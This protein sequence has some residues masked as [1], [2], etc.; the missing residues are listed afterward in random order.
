MKSCSDHVMRVP[1]QGCPQ[2]ECR[3]TCVR[4]Q[5]VHWTNL[6]AL[7]TPCCQ[8]WRRGACFVYA[9][10]SPRMDYSNFTETFA[11]IIRFISAHAKHTS[12]EN[13]SQRIHALLPVT[14]SCNLILRNGYISWGSYC[15]KHGISQS[16]FP[17]ILSWVRLTISLL[18]LRPLP[19][20]C[21]SPRW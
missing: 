7:S 5:W 15:P 3:L 6:R 2:S 12:D 10:W 18:V 21:T 20:Y 17:F 13:Q 9:V 11:T 4:M 1:L 19:T 16:Y 14:T 8:L